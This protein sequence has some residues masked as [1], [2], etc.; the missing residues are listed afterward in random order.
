MASGVA[1]EG[2]GRGRIWKSPRAPTWGGPQ[3]GVKKQFFH[4][5]FDEVV[6]FFYFW[7]PKNCIKKDKMAY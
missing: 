6:Y 7:G 2:G 5:K 3:R 1:K 4:K